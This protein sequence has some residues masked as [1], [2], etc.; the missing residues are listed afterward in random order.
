MRNLLLITSLSMLLISNAEAKNCRKGIPC[1]NTCISA[2]K[3]CRV[4]TPHNYNS[5]PVTVNNLYDQSVT[6]YSPPISQSQNKIITYNC[7]YSKAVLTGDSLGPMEGRY[8]AKV[9]LN[10]WKFTAIRPNGNKMGS[11]LMK[12]KSGGFYTGKDSYYIYVMAE[13][14]NEYA[15]TNIYT[16]ETEQWADCK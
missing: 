6:T 16:K 1:G 9:T 15:I 4:G 14:H 2:N 5:H 10:G 8:Y 3:V 13:N 7:I 12:T 11:P